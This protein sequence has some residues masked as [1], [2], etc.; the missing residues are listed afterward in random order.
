MGSINHIIP[1]IT[2]E[3]DHVKLKCTLLIEL[4]G[5]YSTLRFKVQTDLSAN[6]KI[7]YMKKTI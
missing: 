4:G 6:E 1:D 7:F 5:V 2:I 3:E